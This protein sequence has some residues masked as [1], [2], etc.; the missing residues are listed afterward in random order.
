MGATPAPLRTL[1]L[2]GYGFFGGR[3]ARV[4]AREAGL[5]LIV[6]GRS[7]ERAS[8]YAAELQQHAAQP[9]AATAVD[10]GDPGFSHELACLRPD[11]VIHTS[12]PF[13]E[14]DYRVALACIAAGAHY[15]DLADATGFVSEI[16]TLNAAARER[17]VLVVSGASS[18]P[19]LSSA[20]IA[21]YRSDFSAIESLDIGITPGNRTARG[22]ATVQAVLSYCG[23]PFDCWIDGAWRTVHGW[24]GLKWHAYPAPVGR[25][26]LG[27]C[28]V[29]DRVLYPK[30]CNGVQTVEF[31]AG[32]E[33]PL[34]QLGM[35]CLAWLR[36]CGIVADWQRHAAALKR[37]SEHTMRW[38]S[39]AG[40]MHV[41]IA[42][43]RHDGTAYRVKWYIVAPDGD[44][45]Q[46]PCT[47]AVVIA[48]KLARA[49]MPQRGAMP[50]LELFSVDEFMAALAGFN[51]HETA[52][53]HPG[54]QE[55]G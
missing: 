21:R 25:R 42:G 38:G 47:A 13:Q 43:T 9:V 15:I 8:A 5:Q 52:S 22:L 35:W 26:L 45:P 27:Y 2:G 37:L 41:E 51:V 48:R 49:E 29:P 33:L 50:C 55:Q 10:V 28:D 30:T 18:V 36:R 20:V 24:Q 6:A 3:I 54:D 53:I 1:I 11:L 14:Q 34:L 16:G 46:I 17:G 7:K 39:S 4:L 40:A 23:R 19:G 12:G 32:F 31:R 44:G